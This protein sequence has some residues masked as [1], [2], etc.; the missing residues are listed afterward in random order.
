MTEAVSTRER[1][2]REFSCYELSEADLEKYRRIKDGAKSFALL[3][4]ELCDDS[5]ELGYAISA[6]ENCVI[7]SI[8]A[9]LRGCKDDRKIKP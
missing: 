1:I 4:D 7:F 8:S 9:T 3:L 2:E 5:K 6:L